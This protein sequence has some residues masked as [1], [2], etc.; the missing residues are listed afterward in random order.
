MALYAIISK[1]LD[2]LWAR[3]NKLNLCSWS[4][5]KRRKPSLSS[6]TAAAEAKHTKIQLFCQRKKRSAEANYIMC[7][8][9]LFGNTQKVLKFY[10]HPM[11][12]NMRIC[13]AQFS[14]WKLS[15]SQFF[16]FV[17]RQDGLMTF[18]NRHIYQPK[19]WEKILARKKISKFN[20]LK[21]KK[22]FYWFLKK[23]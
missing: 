15:F 20:F 7:G 13:M 18:K 1:A 12:H 19:H 2:I 5:W 14:N 8:K 11:M 3:T 16:L 10:S 21:K 22:T 4:K 6:S 17:C 23:I 9:S